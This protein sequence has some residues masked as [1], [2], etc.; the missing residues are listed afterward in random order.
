MRKQGI[1]KIHEGIEII[2]MQLSSTARNFAITITN[3]NYN[4]KQIHDLRSRVQSGCEP[5]L[6]YPRIAPACTDSVVLSFTDNCN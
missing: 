3:T 5:R 4:F 1:M 2:D 6:I